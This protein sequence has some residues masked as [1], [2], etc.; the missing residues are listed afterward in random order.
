MVAYKLAITVDMVPKS[1]LD[2]SCLHNWCIHYSATVGLKVRSFY[3]TNES[4]Y[5][6][7]Y[8]VY[9]T[10]AKLLMQMYLSF[11]FNGFVQDFSNYIFNALELL[12]S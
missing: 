7:A 6:F 8:V 12:Q 5:I 4:I 9:I 3:F 10:R 2:I 11:N 1:V